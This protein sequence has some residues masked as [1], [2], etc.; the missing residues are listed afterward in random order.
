VIDLQDFSGRGPITIL[1][2]FYLLSTR[3][4]KEAAMRP[5]QRAMTASG[6]LFRTNKKI[7]GKKRPLA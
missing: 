5:K 7:K 2:F 3:T 1:S 4:M 6:E